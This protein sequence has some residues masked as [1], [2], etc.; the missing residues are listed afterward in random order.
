M[1]AAALYD[2]NVYLSLDVVVLSCEFRDGLLTAINLLLTRIVHV[3]VALP[4][5]TKA[6]N[7]FIFGRQLKSTTESQQNSMTSVMTELVTTAHYS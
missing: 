6:D 1:C 5:L 2:L 7:C 3:F 4:F